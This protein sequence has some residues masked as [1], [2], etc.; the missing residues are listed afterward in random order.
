[1]CILPAPIL[2]IY[3]IISAYS[4]LLDSNITIY[5]VNQQ[6]IGLLTISRMPSSYEH[7]DQNANILVSSNV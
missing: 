5:G 3:S 1:M 6:N 7:E 4:L 2:S